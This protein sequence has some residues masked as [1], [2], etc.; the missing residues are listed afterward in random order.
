MDYRRLFAK[1]ERTLST[2]EPGGSEM[3]LLF[4][5]VRRLLDDLGKELGLRGVR[6]YVLDEQCFRLDR[7]YPDAAGPVG[8]RIPLTYPPVQEL[9]RS[10]FA[11]H[12][13]EDPQVDPAIEGD[14]GVRTF[15]AIAVG[16]APQNLVAFS[17]DD[18]SDLDHVVYTLNTIRHGINLTLRKAR[19]E[20]RVA[21]ARRIQ[22]SLL[23]PTPP[24]FHDYDIWGHTRPAE[25]VGGDL[26]DFIPVSERSMGITVADAAGHGLPAALQARDAIIGLRMGI[27][28]R[29]RITFTIEKLNK[30]VGRS[31]AISRFISLFYCEVEPGGTLVYTNAGAPPPL[32]YRD[33]EFI[34]LSEGGLILGPNPGAT[35]R[36]GYR[37]FPP[38]ATLLAYTDG[39]TE[40]EGR[41]GSMFGV[42][43]LRELVREHRGSARALVQCVFAQL[44]E[45]SAH[46]PP[47][48]D[49]TV[50]A[51]TRAAGS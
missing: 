29:W 39:V 34:E 4:E 19:L 21:Q 40:A 11:V 46:D 44:S 27:E 26:F 8:Y 47:R 30:V 38:G 25:E 45:L 22:A 14:L 51:V 23:P 3:S 41:D 9:L 36:R 43:R 2:V 48:D 33:G 28:E 10:G 18:D 32:L 50:V 6:I 16:E 1:L 13:P 24:R 37:D 35:Y 31:A 20:D 15:A 7:A 5:I 17:M 49:Q 42:E 12:R